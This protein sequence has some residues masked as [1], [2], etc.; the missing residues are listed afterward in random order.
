M[1]DF[2]AEMAETRFEFP[3]DWFV[4]ARFVGR[5]ITGRQHDDADQSRWFIYPQAPTVYSYAWL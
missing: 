2:H 5:G 4:L 1:S 3:R